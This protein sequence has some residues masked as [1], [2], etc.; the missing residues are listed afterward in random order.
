VLREEPRVI[1]IARGSFFLVITACQPRGAIEV[2]DMQPLLAWSGGAA[3]IPK[4]CRVIGAIYRDTDRLQY[5]LRGFIESNMEGGSSATL[6][7]I[8]TDGTPPRRVTVP[9]S[10]QACSK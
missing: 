4:N 7:T 5:V 10:E 2:A 6:E 1:A 8:P 9:L 3:V